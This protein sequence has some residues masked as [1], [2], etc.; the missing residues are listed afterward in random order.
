MLTGPSAPVEGS[1]VEEYE[2]SSLC[3]SRTVLKCEDRNSLAPRRTAAP[4]RNA[5]FLVRQATAE[6][7][8]PTSKRCIVLAL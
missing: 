7:S 8:D 5:P 4:F 2:A 3:E 1:A 6:F